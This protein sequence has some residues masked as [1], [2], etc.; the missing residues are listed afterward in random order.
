MV[1]AEELQQIESLAVEL[2]QLAGAQIVSSLGRTLAVRYKAISEEEDAAFR[3]PVSEVDHAVEVMIRARLADQ[4]PTHGIIGEEVDP[5]EGAAEWTWVIDPVDGTANFVNGF[6]LFASSIGV[7]HLGRPMVGAV[8]C[9]TS[10]A[11]RSGVYHARTGGKLSFDAQPI[12]AVERSQVKRRL[13]GLPRVADALDFGFEGRQTGSAAIECAFVAAG[14]LAGS[15]LNAPN[16]WD[17]AGGIPLV[18][19]VSASVLTR[20][21][22]ET[23]TDFETFETTASDGK[24]SLIWRQPLLIGD[25]AAVAALR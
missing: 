2:A 3:D 11:L 24:R 23:W 5:T 19:A 6:P 22:D 20:S 25:P 10:H 21:S 17:V 13:V 1:Q 14:L 18:Q 16:I 15:K 4:F 7:L 12:E 8:W 9:S